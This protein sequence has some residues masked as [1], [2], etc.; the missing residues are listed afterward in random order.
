MSSSPLSTSFYS[1]HFD[2]VTRGR[3]QKKMSI[4]QT[5]YLAHTARRKLTH[6]ASRADHNLRVLVGH[7]NL[8][9]TLMDDLASAE[10]SHERWLSQTVASCP[11]K[12]KDQAR[13]QWAETV[14]EE[15]EDDWDQE[16]V[17]DDSDSSDDDLDDLDEE[18][19]TMS[20]SLPVPV[21]VPIPSPVHR[22]APEPVTKITEEEVDAEA[23]DSDFEYDHDHDL[24]E[25]TLTRSVARDSPPE[26]LSDSDG[27]SEEDTMPPSPPQP[28]LNAFDEK[29]AKAT[30]TEIPLSDSSQPGLLER[31]YYFSHRPQ[32]ALIPSY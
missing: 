3:P 10:Q 6:E 25:L 19:Y 26:L 9:D 1:S 14:V 24:E 27:E 30:T 18:T 7:A 28:S 5:Y 11:A 13:V 2:S 29:E 31:E 20:G 22:R 21:P 32:G 16:D 23:S 8:L 15:P 4:T 17:S 12:A